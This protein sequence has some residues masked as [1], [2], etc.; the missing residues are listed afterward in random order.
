MKRDDIQ[1]YGENIGEERKPMKTRLGEKV[2]NQGI[3]FRTKTFYQ[4]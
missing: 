4:M 1:K 2:S 3:D